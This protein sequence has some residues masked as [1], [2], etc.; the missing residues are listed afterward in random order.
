[1]ENKKAYDKLHKKNRSVYGIE[2]KI[3]SYYVCSSKTCIASKSNDP[4]GLFKISNHSVK[5]VGNAKLVINHLKSLPDYC[6]CRLVATKN[7]QANQ[8]IMWEYGKEFEFD[9]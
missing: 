3:G 5:A 2:V 9:E 4:R 6:R 7:I 8:E 1:M